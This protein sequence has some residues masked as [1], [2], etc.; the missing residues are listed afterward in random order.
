MWIHG[1]NRSNRHVPFVNCEA[2]FLCVATCLYHAQNWIVVHK[3]RC[4]ELP[5][6]SCK[7]TEKKGA[8][9]EFDTTAQNERQNKNHSS[10]HFNWFT[11]L[12]VSYRYH[13]KKSLVAR[14]TNKHSCYISFSLVTNQY[15]F[16][17]YISEMLCNYY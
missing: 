16:F 4:Q 5:I 10:R 17:L 13:Y 1:M 8:K 6:D 3:I 12:I 14:Q 2:L 11:R 15:A 9:W 7:W